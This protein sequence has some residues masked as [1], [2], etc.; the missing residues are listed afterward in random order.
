M[1]TCP[2]CSAP[3]RENA[4]F[5]GKCG[6]SFTGEI[7]PRKPRPQAATYIQT[8]AP[9][10]YLWGL[11]VLSNVIIGLYIHFSKNTSPKS[12]LALL[13]VDSFL[14]LLFV[15]IK[16]PRTFRLL[17]L[18]GRIP[19]VVLDVLG[20]TALLFLFIK[21]YSRVLSSTGF[22]FMDYLPEYRNAGWPL[23]VPFFTIALWPAL[24]E[25]LTFRGLIFEKLSMV[26]TQREAIILSSL[27]FSIIHLMPAVFISH[28]IIGLAFC[29]L[30]VTHK[31]LYP[32]MAAH[33]LY[34]STVLL[35]EIVRRG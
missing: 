27:L 9:A 8:M 10:L 21:I 34:N 35:D 15:A 33:F 22:E 11:L 25:E 7:L 32:S 24:F 12:T 26:G 16:S 31:S 13:G 29:N 28:F 30:R 6:A 20:T 23:W 3:T 5:C 14:I 17:R 4:R 1:S 2:H 18:P 19:R